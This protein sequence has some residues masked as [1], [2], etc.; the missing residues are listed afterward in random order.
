MFA[1]LAGGLMHPDVTAFWKAIAG[2]GFHGF[3]VSDTG[4]VRGF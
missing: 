4:L 3:R 2:M 1:N